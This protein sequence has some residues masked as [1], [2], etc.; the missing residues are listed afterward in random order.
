MH[1]RPGH[2]HSLHVR[3]SAR[4]VLGSGHALT[5]LEDQLSVL[6]TR[7]LVVA[8]LLCAGVIAVLDGLSMG[9]SLTVAAA[10]AEA[11]LAARA[12][13]LAESRREQVLDLIIDGRGELP[14]EVVARQRTRLLDARR[15]HRLASAFDEIRDE[16]LHPPPRHARVRPIFDRRVITAVAPE[17]TTIARLLRDDAAGLRGIAMAQRLVTQGGSPLYRSD[18]RPLR[19]ELHRLEYHLKR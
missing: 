8:A 17:L 5:R 10:A 13:L 12:A 7:S 18:T 14:I 11:A 2:P 15:R 1:P 6:L 4:E 16:A 19:D 3:P 9:L